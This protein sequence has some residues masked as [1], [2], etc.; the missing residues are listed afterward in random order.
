MRMTLS[1]G[2]VLAVCLL[3]SGRASAGIYNSEEGS[4]HLTGGWDQLKEEIGRLRGIAAPALDNGQMHP[5]R[6]ALLHRVASLELLRRRGLFSPADNANLGAYYLRLNQADKARE[7]LEAVPQEQRNFLVL[8]NLA[9]AYHQ[10]GLLDRAIVTQQQ[11]LD[12]WPKEWPGFTLHDLWFRHRV[13]KLYLALLRARKA[14]GAA[15]PGVPPDSVDDI[16]PGLSFVAP[17]GK[18]AV[19]EMSWEQWEKL[20]PDALALVGYL[21]VDLPLDNR[22]TW[23][24]AELFNANGQ[25]GPALE[26]MS[27]LV[28]NRNFRTPSLMQHRRELGAVEDAEKAFRKS[29]S[30][31]EN[32]VLLMWAMTPRGFGFPLGAEAAYSEFGWQGWAL[33]RRLKAQRFQPQPPPTETGSTPTPPPGVYLPDAKAALVGLAAGLVVGVLVTLQV[34]ASRN[35]RNQQPVPDQRQ[36]PAPEAKDLGTAPQQGAS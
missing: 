20:P 23:L 32:V 36:A 22:L 26:L 28:Q 21:L 8:A 27:E 25:V 12:A 6:V 14:G 7:V 2:A 5:D 35:R 10:E 15:P 16:F 11:A 24:L 9:T 3:V 13:E 31:Q 33:D 30:V 19:G 18:W 17:D 1:A 34:Q 4:F 29:G